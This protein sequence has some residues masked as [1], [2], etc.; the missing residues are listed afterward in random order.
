MMEAGCERAMQPCIHQMIETGCAQAMQFC[1][2]LMKSPQSASSKL[3]RPAA[4]CGEAG[5]AALQCRLVSVR[6]YLFRF[7]GYILE[8][9]VAFIDFAGTYRSTFI[10][11][12]RVVASQ[13][14]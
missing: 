2:H 3:R 12:V 4:T 9:Q 5:Y 13:I 11:E 6:E 10:F 1:T 7:V 14:P 8:L